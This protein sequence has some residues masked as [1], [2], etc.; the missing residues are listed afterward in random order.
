MT[1]LPVLPFWLLAPLAL[2]GL[3]VAVWALAR[4]RAARERALW[5]VRVLLVAACV[6]LALRPGVPGGTSTSVTTNVDVVIALDNTTSMLAED[7]ASGDEPDGAGAGGDAAPA[8]RAD[9]ARA[10]IAALVEAYPGARFA[11]VTFDDSAQLRLPL[12]TDTSA[13]M[14]SL[15]VLSPPPT[16]RSSGSSIGIAAPV[17][18]ETLAGSADDDDRARLVFYL[19]DGEQTAGGEPASFADSAELAG[20]GAVLGYGTEAGGRMP[21]VAAGTG[22]TGEYLEDPST[23][24]PAVSVIDEEALGA[25][26]DDL[27]VDYAHR[28][29]DPLEPPAVPEAVTTTSDA[30]TP[31]SRIEL[32][33]IVALVVAALL[34]IEVGVASGRIARTL[35]ITAPRKEAP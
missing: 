4:A 23:G 15:D 17:V 8:T 19:G 12:T 24:E 30:A 18:A 29:G 1:F 16:D 2:A 35:R 10:D 27:G 7:G 6:V 5:A 25:I 26:A 9:D 31:G 34:A 32:S 22:G 33:W 14:S 21:S 11:L 3:G 28:A 20:G 13:L